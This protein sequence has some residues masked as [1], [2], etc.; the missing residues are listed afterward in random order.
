[1]ITSQGKGLGGCRGIAKHFSLARS[2]SHL[3]FITAIWTALSVAAVVA[4]ATA[5]P[6]QQ[7]ELRKVAVSGESPVGG[8]SGIT[9]GRLADTPAIDNL[10]NVAFSAMDQGSVASSIWISFGGQLRLVAQSGDAAPNTGA[11]FSQF[12]DVV[13]ADGGIV[14]FKATLIGNS[15]D[16]D[17]RESIWLDRAG[18]LALVAQAGQKAP[19]PTADLRFSRFET[20]FSL[21]RDGHVAF[22]ARTREKDSGTAQSSGIWVAGSNGVSLAASEGTV[23][24]TGSPEVLFLPQSFEQPFANDPVLSPSGQAICRG[25]LA[26]P[27]VDESNLNGLWSYTET[28]GL[29]LLQ[30]AGDVAGGHDGRTF[31][32]FPSVPTINAAGDTAFLAFYEAAHGHEGAVNGAS[33][34]G[35]H[36]DTA[37]LGLGLWLR[38]ASGELRH[39][40]AIGDHAPGIEGEVHFVDTFNP[41]LNAASHVAFF[42]VVAG[43]GV[44]TANEIGLWS[45][46]MSSDGSL[47]LVVRQGGEAPGNEQGFVFGTFLEPSFNAAGQTAFMAA[48]YRL[49]NEAVVEN[50]FGIW[51]QD[52]AGTLR[53]VAR[54]GQNLEI[55]AGDEREIASLAFASN[56]GGEDGKPR[57]LNDLGQIVFRAA[58]T[59]G[60]S[61]IFVSDALTTPEPRCGAMLLLAVI[62]LGLQW[63]SNL[64]GNHRTGR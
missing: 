11:A 50:A 62:C 18:T 4:S 14:G 64:V 34:S 55:G 33:A 54:V 24:I 39:I 58:F 52:R 38:R 7:H 43:E 46:G 29:Q 3:L 51:G 30:R 48:G 47:R 40:F 45:N 25:F 21:N 56:T 28:S 26:G 13:I 1:M 27:G 44:S 23:A 9:L 5:G 32:S 41:I 36:E 61:G 53:L 2:R 17:T 20:S 42:A 49:E 35:A 15:I 60:S 57:G 8:A 63:R 6:L 31:L 19:H 12:S 59:D 16:D 10:G 37:E 22:F